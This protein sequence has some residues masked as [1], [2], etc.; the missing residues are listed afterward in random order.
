[1]EPVTRATLPLR[2]RCKAE[3]SVLE[4]NAEMAVVFIADTIRTLK[5]LGKTWSLNYEHKTLA[6]WG[7]NV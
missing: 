3:T 6:C 7:Q 5:K 2:E 1:V 4:L